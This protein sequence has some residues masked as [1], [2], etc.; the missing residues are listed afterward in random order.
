MPIQIQAPDGS[1]AEFPDGTGDETITSV[2]RKSF[3]PQKTFDTAADSQARGLPP[4]PP[5]TMDVARTTGLVG[6]L[7]QAG[8]RTSQGMAQLATHA[9]DIASRPFGDNINAPFKSAANWADSLRQKSET[10]YQQAKQRVLAAS[11]IPGITD[12]ESRIVEGAGSMVNPALAVGAG[13][14]GL[15]SNLARGLAGGTIFGAT[16]PV[17]NAQQGYWAPKA[18][19]IA[20]SALTGAATN[21][22]FG[23]PK[24]P[25]SKGMTTAE[26]KQAGS[27]QFEAFK[28][29]PVPL[30]D[31]FKTVISGRY[32][33]Q[34][35]N[36]AIDGAEALPAIGKDA[37]KRTAL[38]DELKSLLPDKDGNVNFPQTISAGAA[39]KISRA[40]RES[41]VKAMKA[42]EGTVSAGMFARRAPI[43][44]QLDQ[45]PG[46]AD[47]R[48]LYRQ[49]EKSDVIDNAIQTA[50]DLTRTPGGTGSLD[51]SLR[52]EFGKIIRNRDLFDSFSPEEQQAIIAVRNGTIG[53]NVLQRI[54]KLSPVSNHLSALTE[55]GM[56]MAGGALG[57]SDIGVIPAATLAGTG[58]AAHAG[59]NALTMRNAQA[60]SQLIR[61]V[62]PMTP[63]SLPAQPLLGTSPGFNAA[64]ANA[65]LSPFIQGLLKAGAYQGAQ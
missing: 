21:A 62:R 5:S 3:P 51:Q 54:G 55:L 58:L 31:D 48:Q 10:D 7:I 56:A 36:D 26:L 64:L 42:D 44:A 29:T 63:M 22:A 52:V 16:Q 20:V 1:I 34:A 61:G 17:D 15:V 12:A 27:D 14:G 40:F 45:V 57:H 39:D 2:M 32:G 47:A 18:K 65:S 59:A 19:Q 4:L 24:P 50:K 60:A 13:P 28:P 53:A 6:P 33:Q 9:A 43:E 23:A 25:S 49:Y 8:N 35:I 41:G 37:A 46:V 30:S 38:V 11:G